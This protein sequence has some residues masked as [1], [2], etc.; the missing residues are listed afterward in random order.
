MFILACPITRSIYPDA[1]R[2]V[3]HSPPL[4]YLKH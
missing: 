4:R 3:N 2:F 1:A